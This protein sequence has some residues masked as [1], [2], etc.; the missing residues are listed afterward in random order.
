M[1]L[2]RSAVPRKGFEIKPGL[3]DEVVDGS[4]KI[5]IRLQS[6]SDALSPLD[7]LE[8]R[9]AQFLR[10]YFGRIERVEPQRGAR[11]LRWS[12][13]MTFVALTPQIAC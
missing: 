9:N 6:A 4:L 5:L 3:R 13:R 1:I 8:R 12:R 10:K 7:W 11:H 2:S